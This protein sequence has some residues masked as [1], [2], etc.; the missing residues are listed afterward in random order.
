VGRIDDRRHVTMG[1]D[2]L[3]ARVD[4]ELAT[5]LPAWPG[6]GERMVARWPDALAQYRLGHAALVARARRAAAAISVALAGAAYDG[7]GIPASIGSGRR[8]AVDALGFL[9]RAST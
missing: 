7:V 1:D 9:G 8:G 4:A 5:I 6:G 2:E 3:A